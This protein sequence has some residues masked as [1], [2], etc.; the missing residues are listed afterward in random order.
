MLEADAPSVFGSESSVPPASTNTMPRANQMWPR[1]WSHRIVLVNVAG[2]Q[3]RSENGI[4]KRAGLAW[5]PA[6]PNDEHTGRLLSL[7]ALRRLECTRR[8]SASRNQRV[9]FVIG[10][11]GAPPPPPDLGGAS[12]RTR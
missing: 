6:S 7:G 8:P 12:T 5:S 4:E 9:D 1:G 10:P 3:L 11:R 2:Q